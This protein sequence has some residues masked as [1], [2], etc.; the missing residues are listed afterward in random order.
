MSTQVS[1]EKPT[2]SGVRIRTR[3]RD[4]KAKAKYEPE[5]FRDSLFQ[6]IENVDPTDYTKFSSIL[7][8]AGNTLDYRRYGDSFFELLVTGGLLAPGGIINDDEEYGKYPFSLFAMATGADALAGARR[9]GGL[10]LK[11]TRRYKYLE[12]TFSESLVHILKSI[13]RYTEEENKK[14]AVGVGVLVGEGFFTLEPLKTLQ[15]DHLTKEGVALRFLTDMLQVYLLDNNIKQLHKLLSKAKIPSLVEFFPPNKR[16]DDCFARHFEAEDMPQ[17]I[18]LHVAKQ[19]SLHRSGFVQGVSAILRDAREEESDEDEAEDREEM[20]QAAN[21]KVAKA[22]KAAMRANKWEQH[23]AVTLVWD[24]IMNAVH[25]SFKSEQIEAQALRQISRHSPVLE[26]LTT[27]PKS[28][29]SLLKHVQTY[30]YNEPRL[31][32]HFGRI[33][34]ELYNTDVLSDSA[35]IF[36]ATKGAKP[37]GKS[38]FLKQTEALVRN[39]EA[40]ESDSEDGE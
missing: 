23:Q 40:L 10:I 33:V 36:W 21:L 37:E 30:A 28:E 32:K 31:T 5:A 17:L 9:W 18:E 2:L 38:G 14:L 1:N 4:A 22:A 3:K 8:T 6:L 11:L 27:E 7:D 35:I 16:D 19:A 24:G 25:W 26:M 15:E 34:L 20:V 39:L 13:H 29:I 12:R